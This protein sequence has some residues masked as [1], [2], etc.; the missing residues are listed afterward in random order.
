MIGAAAGGGGSVT[1]TDD[2]VIEKSNLSRQFLFRDWNIGRC[3][4]ASS[5]ELH[6]LRYLARLLMKLMGMMACLFI[7][8]LHLCCLEQSVLPS[9][10]QYMQQRHVPRTILQGL[11]CAAP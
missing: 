4:Y 9:A 2:D 3:C 5:E 11:L 8:T 6:S 7:V 1:V 10:H